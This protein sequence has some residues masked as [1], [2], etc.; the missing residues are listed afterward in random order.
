MFTNA[1]QLKLKKKK[2]V[3]PTKAFIATSAPVGATQYPSSNDKQSPRCPAHIDGGAQL[4]S[5]LIGGQ[6]VVE[7]SDN[8]VSRPADRNEAEQPGHNEDH[9]S[10]HTNVGFGQRVL[11]KEVG[12]A[13]P[14]HGEPY[15]HH[16]DSNGDTDQS[17]GGL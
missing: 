1:A 5:P 6:R 17:S 3:P 7:T 11:M 13:G 12:A 16:T 9:T 14:H 2:K 15:G 4:P 8:A 10:R